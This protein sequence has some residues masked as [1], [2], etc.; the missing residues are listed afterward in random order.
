VRI[1]LGSA[2]DV[3]GERRQVSFSVDSSRKTMTEEIEIKVRNQK[4]EPVAVLVQEN[5]YRWTNWTITQKTHDYEKRD[6]RTIQFPIEIA[7]GKEASVRYTVQY[8]W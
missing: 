1:K 8:T 6:A 2:F 7:P 4:K 5:L 3:V